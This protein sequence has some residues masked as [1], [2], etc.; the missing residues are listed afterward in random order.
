M[1][2]MDYEALGFSSAETYSF[3]AIVNFCV[4]RGRCPS[5]VFIALWE[6]FRILKEEYKG[7]QQQ[8]FPFQE[9]C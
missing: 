2:L 9:N 1:I 3:P 8:P 6:F 4:I 5:G 7:T